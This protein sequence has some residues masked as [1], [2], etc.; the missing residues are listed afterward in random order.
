M[1]NARMIGTRHSLVRAL[2][3]TARCV[4]NPNGWDDFVRVLQ[5]K[6]K[7]ELVPEKLRTDVLRYLVDVEPSS[8]PKVETNTAGSTEGRPVTVHHSEPSITD[9]DLEAILS[10]P[11]K[12]GPSDDVVCS[13][14]VVEHIEPSPAMRYLMQVEKLIQSPF[15]DNNDARLT[16]S[17]T[18]NNIR[19]KGLPVA[20]VM[21]AQ[22]TRRKADGTRVTENINGKIGQSLIRSCG[23]DVL[24]FEGD[25]PLE[26]RSSF[27]CDIKGE[28]VEGRMWFYLVYLKDGLKCTLWHNHGVNSSKDLRRKAF[29]FKGGKLISRDVF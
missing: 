24:V 27:K 3:K 9:S 26:I 28:P 15:D 23:S 22:F 29:E 5:E 7:T 16:L 21:T 4:L 17:P 1:E 19:I 13:D 12:S 18:L 2:T 14:V 25:E 6:M 20:L 8:T 11:I 10:E